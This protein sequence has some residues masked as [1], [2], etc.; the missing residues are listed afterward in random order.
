MRM[1]SRRAVLIIAASLLAVT[2]CSAPPPAP[3]VTPSESL[4]RYTPGV[5]GNGITLLSPTAARQTA[6]AAVRAERGLVMSG[7][8]RSAGGR[9]LTVH[10]E[11]S[12]SAFTAEILVDGEITRFVVDGADAWVDPAPTLA[13]ETDYPSGEWACVATS[14]PVITRWAPLL[15]PGELVASL[16]VDASGLSAPVDDA[17]ELLLG[18]EGA[19]GI[20]TISATGTAL[21]TRLVRSD[22][23]GTA[24]FTFEVGGEAEPAG[25][26]ANC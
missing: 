6:L 1:S 22:E 15:D 20:L 11:G 8:Y 16:T 17:V 12:Q 3:L 2:G 23:T 10:R 18:S 13:A 4:A 9:E 14:D 19:T 26:P 25:A 7:T 24:A 21:P 5:Q